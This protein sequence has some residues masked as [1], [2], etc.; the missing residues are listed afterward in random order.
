MAN[1]LAK[2]SLRA[3][4]IAAVLAWLLLWSLASSA[5]AEEFPV[6]ALTV[7]AGNQIALSW[8]SDSNHWYRVERCDNLATG[9]WEILFPTANATPPTNAYTD[10]AVGADCGFYRVVASTADWSHTDFGTTNDDEQITFGTPNRDRIVQFGGDG[11]DLQSAEGDEGNDWIEQ[12]GE[13]GMDDQFV[14]GGQEDEFIYQDGGEGNDTE[15]AEGSEGNDQI[16]Q[17][18]G[19]GDDDLTATG[20]EGDDFIVQRGGPGND[21]IFAGGGAGDDT[22]T[23]EGGAGDDTISYDVWSGQDTVSIDGGPDYDT[24]TIN[25]NNQGFRVL[26]AQGQLLYEAGTGGS[27]T[28]VKAVEHIEVLGNTGQVVFEWP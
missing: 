9:A 5:R 14:T 6:T 13:A 1:N 10:A 25:S 21:S 8:P 17:D 16:I 11:N 3:E 18:D 24:L 26:D 28:T 27:V 2:H 20:D 19:M 22:I 23:I 7:G 12:F 4:R 15:Y